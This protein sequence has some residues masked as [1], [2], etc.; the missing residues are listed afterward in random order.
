MTMLR[1][2]L[3]QNRRQDLRKSMALFL[4]LMNVP[5]VLTT[6]FAMPASG[7]LHVS[8]TSVLAA[9]TVLVEVGGNDLGAPAGAAGRQHCIGWFD[10]GRAV[11]RAAT[12]LGVV[13]VYVEDAF[14][15]LHKI[16]EG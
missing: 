6:G 10:A 2:A 7:T 11:S 5:A 1:E 8:T 9:P 13:T 12:A 14:G 4:P 16:A 3:N 15:V